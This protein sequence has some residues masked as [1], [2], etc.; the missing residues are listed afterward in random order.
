MVY[1]F[2]N[3]DDGCLFDFICLDNNFTMKY[4]T[5]LLDKINSIDD[6][7]RSRII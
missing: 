3:I 7:H 4:K 2:L 1:C 6:G 5:N